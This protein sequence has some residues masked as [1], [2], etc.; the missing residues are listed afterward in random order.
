MNPTLLLSILLVISLLM[1]ATVDVF[2]Q[3]VPEG[4]AY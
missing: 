2:Q 3:G 4:G 1:V